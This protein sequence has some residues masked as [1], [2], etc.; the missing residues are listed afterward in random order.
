MEDGA[1]SLEGFSVLDRILTHI[2]QII[3]GFETE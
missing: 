2:P 1:P 3:N